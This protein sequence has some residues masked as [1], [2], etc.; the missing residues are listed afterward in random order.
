MESAPNSTVRTEA[1]TGKSAH[2]GNNLGDILSFL[3]DSCLFTQTIFLETSFRTRDILKA[4]AK[5]VSG[6]TSISKLRQ[7]Q[8]N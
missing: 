5:C 3:T 4:P 6:E 8:S 2:L 7:N 1:K